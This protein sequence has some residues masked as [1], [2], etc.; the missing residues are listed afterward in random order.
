MTDCVGSMIVLFDAMAEL[1]QGVEQRSHITEQLELSVGV[2]GEPSHLFVLAR[3]FGVVVNSNQ[4]HNPNITLMLLCCQRYISESPT[5][6][7]G[8]KPAKRRLSHRK[9]KSLFPLQCG[10]HS[11][12]TSTVGQILKPASAGLETQ[13]VNEHLCRSTGQLTQRHCL[14]P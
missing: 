12:G 3:E 4:R 9:R 11:K 5:T 13:D 6:S 1:F 2:P 14:M 8:G 7:R 10:P